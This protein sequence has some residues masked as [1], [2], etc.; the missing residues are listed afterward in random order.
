MIICFRGRSPMRGSVRY[1]EVVPTLSLAKEGKQ[2]WCY[3]K[4]TPLYRTYFD[5]YRPDSEQV[6]DQP[7]SSVI[8]ISHA[9]DAATAAPDKRRTL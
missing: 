2:M 9:T 6:A 3:G 1:T 8:D 4:R 7:L 5:L